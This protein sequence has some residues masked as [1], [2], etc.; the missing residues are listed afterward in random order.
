MISY[1]ADRVYDNIDVEM[2][3]LPFSSTESSSGVQGHN[4]GLLLGSPFDTPCEFIINP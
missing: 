3:I 4:A 2:I 1:I